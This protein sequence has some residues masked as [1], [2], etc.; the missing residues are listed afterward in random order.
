MTKRDFMTM[1]MNGEMTDEMKD[2]ARAEIEKLDATL[3]KRKNTISKKA[4]ENIPLMDRIY[5]EILGEEAKTA[6]DVAEVMEISVQKASSLLRKMVEDGRATKT[7]VK[8]PKKGVQKGYTK[9][10]VTE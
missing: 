3:E 10:F 7:E 1:V 5:D 2:F 8:I 6:T 9:N 4:L